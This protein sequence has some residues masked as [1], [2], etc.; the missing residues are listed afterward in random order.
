MPPEFLAPPIVCMHGA[1]LAQELDTCLGLPR[2]HSDANDAQV[3]LEGYL[4]KRTTNAFKSWV[5]FVQA[6]P[7]TMLLLH[8][9]KLIACSI[10]F[11]TLVRYSEEPVGVPQAFSRHAHR[12]GARL[13][14]VHREESLRH[15]QTLLLR[16]DFA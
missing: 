16:T 8:F 4:F 11:Q 10:S 12:D 13:A 7:Y 14:V 2:R 15:R 9:Q 5:R 3:K 1:S 6:I